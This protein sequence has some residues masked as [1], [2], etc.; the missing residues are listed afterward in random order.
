MIKIDFVPPNCICKFRDGEKKLQKWL[1]H[2]SMEKELTKRLKGAEYTEIEFVEYDFEKWRKTAAKA[3]EKVIKAFAGKKN[4]NGNGA[5][6][7][8]GN[9]NGDG[10]AK[11]KPFKFNEGI[12]KPL[13]PYFVQ[14]FYEK[15]AY[16]E[17]GVEAGATTQ[18]EHY[19]PK[20]GKCIDGK[21]GYY[22]LAYDETN[23]VPA[24]PKC[25]GKKSSYFPLLADSVQARSPADSLAAEKPA[26]LNPSLE[27]AENDLY[28]EPKIGTKT[29]GGVVRPLSERGAETIKILGWN[30]RIHLVERRREV[31]LK[32]IK[33]FGV[34]LI[35]DPKK[36]GKLQRKLERGRLEYSAAQ[37]AQLRAMPE[38]V[39]EVLKAVPEE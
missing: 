1:S 26:L 25:N 4:G 18:V 33:D 9:G 32:L 17:V 28:F 24:C 37:L 7:G 3:T 5:G 27:G 30:Q 22:W 10:E 35:A 15:C 21:H 12:W 16:C 39:T 34:D 11:E 31:Q 14:L 8:N 2:R 19:R 38:H 29:L 13:R 6:N 23:Y 20:S 36:V